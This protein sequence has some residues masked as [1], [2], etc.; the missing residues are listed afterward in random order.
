M[1]L[2]SVV[3]AVAPRK[4]SS[5]AYSRSVFSEDQSHVTLFVTGIYLGVA[6]IGC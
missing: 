4:A 6:G 1:T 5:A 3:I 2:I